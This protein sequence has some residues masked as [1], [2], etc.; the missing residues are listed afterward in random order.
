MLQQARNPAHALLTLAAVSM[1]EG[2][3]ALI[4][5]RDGVPS[6]DVPGECVPLQTDTGVLCKQV[7]L[8]AL[9]RAMEVDDEHTVLH[10][11][12]EGERDD[13]G[14][15]VRIHRHTHSL[16]TVHNLNYLRKVLN[17]S[18]CF[19]HDTSS[20]ARQNFPF[21]HENAIT[22]PKNWYHFLEKGRISASFFDYSSLF[23]SSVSLPR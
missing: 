20:F 11:V 19:S 4:V 12:A 16:A 7:E 17:F 14:E 1:P 23:S 6:L 3:N 18:V 2:D 10:I 5:R 8:S 15:V 21:G 13:I 9:R 22:Y